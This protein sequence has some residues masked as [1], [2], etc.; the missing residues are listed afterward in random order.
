MLLFL[1]GQLLFPPE[2]KLISKKIEFSGSTLVTHPSIQRCSGERVWRG[3]GGVPPP[4]LPL[5][6]STQVTSGPS[7]KP[8]LHSLNEPEKEKKKQRC[9]KQYPE[10]SGV[11]PGHNSS[12]E[13]RPLLCHLNYTATPP[14]I[15]GSLPAPHHMTGAFP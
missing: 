2:R 10:G 7:I 12:S 11:I 6:T 8:L 9:K 4:P 1:R 14:L 15:W 13:R 3:R 5:K